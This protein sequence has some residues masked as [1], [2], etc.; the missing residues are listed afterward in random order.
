MNERNLI[1]S[2]LAERLAVLE[3]AQDRASRAQN[4][5]RRQGKFALAL[6]PVIL[7]ALWA[8]AAFSQTLTTFQPGQPASAAAVNA[9]FEQLR[10]NVVP[11]GSI[12]AFG[13]EAVP[14]NYLLCNGQAVSRTEYPEL[15][16]AIGTS[17]GPGD[18]GGTFNVPDLRG[19][20]PRGAHSAAL[21]TGGNRNVGSV[22]G[23]EVGWHGHSTNVGVGGDHSHPIPQYHSTTLY[24]Y[25]AIVS[26]SQVVSRP[27]IAT[28]NWNTGSRSAHPSVSVTVNNAGGESRPDNAAVNFIIRTGR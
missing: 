26:G 20:F 19:R 3:A 28:W 2:A 6:S 16:A 22:Q 12:L 18:G 14:S 1:E 7:G 10:A 9:N 25:S 4:D 11:A 8:S 23:E 21:D 17:W 24:T 13:G 5:R 27:D 15:F